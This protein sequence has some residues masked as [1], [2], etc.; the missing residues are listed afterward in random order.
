MTASTSCSD[1]DSSSRLL[2]SYYQKAP[3]F[4]MWCAG[5]AGSRPKSSTHPPQVR[6]GGSSVPTA[7]NSRLFL[8][9]SVLIT[10][11]YAFYLAL[12]HLFLFSYLF[13][14]SI[15]TD[16]IF[17]P[18]GFYSVLSFAGD[19][20]PGRCWKDLQIK[21]F[22]KGFWQKLLWEVWHRSLVYIQ[23]SIIKGHNRV[24]KKSNSG[25]GA[26]FQMLASP[27]Y[28][29]YPLVLECTLTRFRHTHTHTQLG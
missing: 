26:V 1:S 18:V 25:R 6:L 8:M 7:V 17:P 13:H 9:F 15:C 2:K 24:G 23:A 3:S 22:C 28:S 19:D 29:N 12:L 21:H 16:K 4:S 20:A 14:D 10:L 27:F 5:E 11:Y